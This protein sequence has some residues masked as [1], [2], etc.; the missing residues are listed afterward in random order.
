M[1]AN[2]IRKKRLER[3]LS[4][5]RLA[6]LCETSSNVMSSVER[7]ELKPWPKLRKRIAEVLGCTEGELF[8][9]VNKQ[10]S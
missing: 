10:D 7:G 8:P 9:W 6:C 5:T 3:G 1:F 4:Q 2:N